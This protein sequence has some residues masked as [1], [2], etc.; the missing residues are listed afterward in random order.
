MTTKETKTRIDILTASLAKKEAEFNRRIAEH[1][2]SVKAAN[3]QPL[4]D[5]RG[6]AATFAKWDK[7]NDGLRRL[8]AEIEK[9]KAAIERENRKIQRVESVEGDIPAFI[10][11][12]VKSGTLQQWRRHPTYFFVA[13]VTK[14]R[15][16]W[17]IEKQ[18][19]FIKYR[20]EVPKEQWPKFAEVLKDL[21]AKK[22]EFDLAKNTIKGV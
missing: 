12:L 22:A 19:I 4:N 9:T 13:G 10:M 1:F 17:D 11:D 2:D 8:Q 14:G 7:Q 20:S 3:G 16:I 18:A 5:K 6:G 15:I 21:L